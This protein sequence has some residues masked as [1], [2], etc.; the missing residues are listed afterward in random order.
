MTSIGRGEEGLSDSAVVE[1]TRSSTSR[2]VE[3]P[4]F[5]HSIEPACS[6]GRPAKSMAVSPIA[7]LSA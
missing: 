2:A 1:I 5:G 6:D 7:A 4:V 3:T